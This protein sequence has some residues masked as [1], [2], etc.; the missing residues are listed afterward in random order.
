MI[1][2]CVDFIILIHVDIELNCIV[3]YNSIQIMLMLQYGNGIIC[4]DANVV[5][6]STESILYYTETIL[7]YIIL[8]VYH[9]FICIFGRC[10]SAIYSGVFCNF[11]HAALRQTPLR[12]IDRL[13]TLRAIAHIWTA[14][15]STSSFCFIN[16]Y[17]LIVSVSLPAC[18]A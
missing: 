2:C 4:N 8:H 1:L 9:L 5:A 7:Y 10:T 15:S 18:P 12:D 3:I 6:T 11:P 17:L 13:T 14:P 16:S